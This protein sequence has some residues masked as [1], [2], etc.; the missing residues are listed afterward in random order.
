[1]ITIM[2][3]TAEDRLDYGKILT[4][5]AGY[6]C[7][8]AIGTT[9]SLDL[10]TLIGVPLS[11]YLAE[12]MDGA[13][14][15]NPVYVLEGLRKSSDKLLV[16]CEGGQIKVP[17][18]ANL[19]FSLLEGSV[20]EVTVAGS[21]SFHPK[22]WLLKYVSDNEGPLYRFIVLSRNLTF[23]RSWDTAVV[24]EGD[25]RDKATAKN[26]PLI[27]FLKYLRRY[28][29]SDKKKKLIN[30]LAAELPFVHFKTGDKHFT[31]FR[32][33]PLGIGEKY[34]QINSG[35]F[36]TYH[37]ILIFSPFLS[38]DT[39]TNFHE[40]ALTNANKTLITRRSAIPELSNELLK[41]FQTYC[42]KE[43]LVD[44]EE[45]ISESEGIAADIQKQDIH[46]KLYFRSKYSEHSLYIGSANCSKSAWNGNVE[47]MLQL[48]YEKWGFRI[49][50]VIDEL[51]GKKGE[52]FDERLNP[53]ERIETVPEIIIPEENS[54][55]I[56]EKAI[57]S[58]C[59][60]RAKAFVSENN[61]RYDVAVEFDSKCIVPDVNLSI[62]TLDDFKSAKIEPVTYLRGLSLTDLSEFYL[63]KAEYQ[64]N[65]LRRI[66]KIR[67]EGIPSEREEVVFKSVIKDMHAFIQY[68]AFLLSDDYI[69]S[70][71][72]QGGVSR[73]WFNGG[74]YNE[75]HMPVLYETM[76]R[77]AAQSPQKM[78]DINYVIKKINDKEII[79]PE[80]VKL[81][82]TFLKASRRAV[83]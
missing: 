13:L 83:Q 25:L 65:S 21:Y 2:F 59:R 61:N 9:Y 30:T 56:M 63:V 62:A 3:K 27:D 47:F 26:E 77:A 6:T 49:S 18:K 24:L 41:S 70:A 7:D 34:N 20:Y 22:M 64:A 16:F 35:L 66:L 73:Q 19:L 55:R 14:A 60:A 31:D 48:K 10:E 32:F 46:A 12:D 79:P 33:L 37:D 50:Q 52:D 67:T 82:Q 58:L 72:E 76:L 54:E 57:K 45:A 75:Y 80:F 78:E 17:D 5:P 4:P 71:L 53:F 15:G 36:E 42:L 29:Y 1:M 39:V 51:F 81:Y 8:C 11:L 74:A 23:D 43:T 44:G 40:L 38:K 28:T 69:L 68:I